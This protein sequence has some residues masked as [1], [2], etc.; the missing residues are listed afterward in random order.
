MMKEHCAE[1]TRIIAS[2]EESGEISAEA[3]EFFRSHLESCQ[4]CGKQ[5]SALLPFFGRDAGLKHHAEA[6]SNSANAA[7]FADRVM[8][9]IDAG[10][11]Q[12]FPVKKRTHVPVAA[13]AAVLLIFGAL[14]FRFLIFP[15]GRGNMQYIKISFELAAPE[16][17]EVHLVGDFTDWESS[18]ITL[19]DPDGDGVWEA[20]V[21]LKKGDV[22]SY[23]FVIDGEEWIP[24]PNSLTQVDDGFGGQSSLL[25]L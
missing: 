22:Y 4:E 23:N 17:E 24:D 3:Y 2:W 12:A 6:A 1:I 11:K 15:P 18:K 10:G 14:A 5:Y 7:E 19:Q 8:D 21:K 16:A 25:S 20:E 13:A 9:R